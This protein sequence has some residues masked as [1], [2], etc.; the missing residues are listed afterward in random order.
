ML[1]EPLT[2]EYV[3]QLGFNYMLRLFASLLMCLFTLNQAQAEVKTYKNGFGMFTDYGTGYEMPEY[4]KKRPNKATLQTYLKRYIDEIHVFYGFKVTPSSEAYEFDFAL[5]DEPFIREQLAETALLSY[6]LFENGQIIVDELTPIKRFGGQVKNDTPLPSRSLGK[7]FSSYLLGHAIC[8]GF[9]ESLDSTISDWDMVKG[10][11]YENQRLIDLVN[12][13]AGDQ[14]FAYVNRVFTPNGKETGVRWESL[15]THYRRLQDTQPGER[16]YNYND[17]AVN[18]VTNYIRFKTGNNFQSFTK[19]F[20]QNKIG[21]AN[22]FYLLAVDDTRADIDGE[23]GSG[24][25]LPHFS[26]SRYDF[27]RLA[28][29]ML[30]DWQ[31]DTCEGKYL[32]E[33]FER[34]M[35]KDRKDKKFQRSLKRHKFPN[36]SFNNYA[37]YFHT[38]LWNVPA[39]RHII[40]MDGFGGQMIWIDFDES[41]IVV[42]N[43]IYNNYKWEKIVR[44]V[45]R[46][47]KI[48]SNNWN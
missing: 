13:R 19:D 43:A 2:P 29:A 9:I 18:T 47:G 11:V 7:S 44:D 38:R 35:P 5:R 8:S 27:L 20:L 40:A 30:D 4:P 42:T 34:Q 17:L 3:S 10:T 24:T 14:D 41:R 6:L 16:Y 15:K 31:N 36:R 46:N 32:K 21:I 48:N 1:I 28:K 26:A 39:H 33:I 23:I 12:M 25:T 22:D 37:G 45:I